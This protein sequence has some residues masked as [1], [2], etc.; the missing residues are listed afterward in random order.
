LGPAPADRL[1]PDLIVRLPGGQSVVVD[2]KTPMEAYLRASAADGE[3]ERDRYLQDSVRQVREHMRALSTK[4]YWEQFRQAPELVVMFLPEPV[5]LTA[6]RLDPTFLEDATQQRVFPASPATLIVLLKAI[7]YGW[8]QEKIAENAQ[9]ISDLGRDL[10]QRLAKLATHFAKLGLEIGRTVD[11]YNAAVGSLEGRVLV[12]ARRFAELG[13]ASSD[14]IPE[15]SPVDHAPRGPNAPELVEP[16][17][18]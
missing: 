13:A 7:A 3:A 5:Y 9:R 17:A 8:R 10:Y 2:A 11:A 15:I 1:R 4:A 14:E 12:Q 18:S 6:L 16:K